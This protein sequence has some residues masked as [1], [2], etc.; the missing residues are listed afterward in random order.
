MGVG[1]IF[2]AM[3]TMYAAVSQRTREIAVLLTLGFSKFSIMTSF[4][5]ESVLLALVG[6]VLGCLLALPINGITT[7]TTNWSSF[8][9]VAFAFRVTPLGLALGMLFA[10]GMGLIGGFLPARKASNQTL[11]ASLR[12]M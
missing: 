3:N 2:G 12:A 5:F 4:L 6:G 9:E 11:A 8:S 7:S 10:V 1:A